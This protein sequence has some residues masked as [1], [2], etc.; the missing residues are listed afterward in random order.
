MDI[1][2]N[3]LSRWLEDTISYLYNN[4]INS[5]CMVAICEDGSRAKSYFRASREAKTIMKQQIEDDL[6]LELIA[7][8]KERIEELEEELNDGEADDGEE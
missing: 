8:N 3:E 6:I 5:V 2:N 7:V 4:E 1:P